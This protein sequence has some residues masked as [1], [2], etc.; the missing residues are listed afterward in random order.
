[1]VSNILIIA[2]SAKDIS[3]STLSVSEKNRE[4][5]VVYLPLFALTSQLVARVN[6]ILF[7]LLTTFIFWF[8]FRA[9]LFLLYLTNTVWCY[10]Q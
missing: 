2:K 10:R 1:M 4:T 8:Y 7:F 9:R 6:V 5:K 3:E